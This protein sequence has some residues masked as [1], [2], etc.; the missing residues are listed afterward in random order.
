[1]NDIR[2]HCTNKNTV[3]STGMNITVQFLKSPMKEESDLT[4]KFDR[5]FPCSSHVHI[6]W[7]IWGLFHMLLNKIFNHSIN[8]FILSFGLNKTYE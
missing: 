8:K 6:L 2:K 3:E 5:Q 4:T 1:M 7:W